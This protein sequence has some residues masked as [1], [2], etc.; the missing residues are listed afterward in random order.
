MLWLPSAQQEFRH[1]QFLPQLPARSKQLTGNCKLSFARVLQKA[2]MLAS[3]ANLTQTSAWAR[4]IL[5]PKVHGRS[6]GLQ[7]ALA[8][9]RT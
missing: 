6:A 2:Y 4:A 8:Y 5:D 9:A 3:C 1:Q 7:T